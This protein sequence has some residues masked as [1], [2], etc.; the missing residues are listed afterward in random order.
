MIRDFLSIYSLR[1]PSTLVYM[2]QSTEYKLGPYFKWNWRTKNYSN[3]MKRRQLDRTRAARLLLLALRLGILLQI[4]IAIC[5]IV[6]GLKQ[7]SGIWLWLGSL[8]LLSY[9]LIWSFLLTLPIYL[10]RLL[11]INPKNKKL[12]KKAHKIF[13][14]HKGIKIAVAGS[15][16]K[17]TMKEIMLTVLSEGKKTAATPANRNVLSSHAEFAS[18]LTGNEEV[19]IIEYGEGEPG[20]VKRFTE[21]A[22]PDMGVITGI[23]PAHLDQYKTLAAAAE[24]IFYLG[25]FLKGKP[26]YVNAES[27][28]A[29]PYI[30]VDQ[31]GYSSAGVGKWKVS[32]VSISPDRTSFI[33]S[34]GNQK[35]KLK[36]ELLGSHQIGPLSA[37]AAIADSLGLSKQQIEAGIAKVQAFE[38][39]MQPRQLHGA[40][41]IDD[42]YNGNIEG[43]QAGLKLLNLLPAKRRVY[44]TPGLVDQG[45][46]TIRVH[47]RLGKLIAEAKPDVVVLMKNSVTKHI[48]V[49]L[50][51]D[52]KGELVIK[53][54]PLDFYT[55]LEAFV[56]AGD[57]VLMQ[58]D[59]TDN[60][61]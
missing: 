13:A 43:M 35:L 53:N 36:S 12:V 45:E 10:G 61:N 29:Q 37:A 7:D 9:P 23:A 16:G 8:V 2:L 42:T 40:W 28:A 19:L 31:I 30:T 44:V 55:N 27:E 33:L 41:I 49:G 24:D 48:L 39:R 5:L 22:A 46:E 47:Q 14:E 52:F 26:L 32:A 60:Y 18:K 58:N 11:I 6:F 59:W 34:R 56:A 3:V 17:T 54:D 15:Y 4:V 57:I 38:H 1:F 25:D 21:L 50:G 51:Q 20:D